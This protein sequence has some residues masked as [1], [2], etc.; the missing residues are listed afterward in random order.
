MTRRPPLRAF[1]TA[2]ITFTVSTHR[3]P[4]TKTRPQSAC[5]ARKASAD[6]KLEKAKKTPPAAA[7]SASF[8]K[9][10]ATHES[11][12]SA[13]DAESRSSTAKHHGD[14]VRK[15]NAWVVEKHDMAKPRV[16]MDPK[17]QLVPRPGNSSSPPR[18]RQ[19]ESPSPPRQTVVAPS[20]TVAGKHP[21][22]PRDERRR[23]QQSMIVDPENIVQD[24]ERWSGAKWDNERGFV[25]KP[26][27][28]RPAMVFHDPAAQHAAT[29]SSFGRQVKQ[30]GNK[31]VGSRHSR[32]AHVATAAPAT[33]VVAPWI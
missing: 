24:I 22:P 16:R 21:P 29:P 33:P 17:Q 30:H 12:V 2:D 27:S 23:Q 3:N 25:T 19:H 9:M 6:A 10:N 5:R 8:V 32:A 18:H 4:P 13:L 11:T 20:T 14:G 31:G 7:R 15:S 28:P 26:S 1:A